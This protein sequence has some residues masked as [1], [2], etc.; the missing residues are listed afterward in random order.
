[1]DVRGNDLRLAHFGEDCIAYPRK[2][3]GLDTEYLGGQ[4][5]ASFSMDSTLVG[6]PFSRRRR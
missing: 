5:A 1:M 4:V 2:A 3:P 6:R